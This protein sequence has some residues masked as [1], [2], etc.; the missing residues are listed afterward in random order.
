[1]AGI[2]DALGA[3]WESLSWEKKLGLMLFAGAMVVLSGGT[4]GLAFEVGMGVATVLGSARGAASLV[5]DPQGTVTRYLST[6]T[7]TEI[8]LDLATAALTT[9]GA[10]A[11]SAMGGQM[12]RG[13][14]AATREAR[15]ASWLWRTDRTAW[16]H[17]VR[18]TR[19]LARDETG[20]TRLPDWNPHASLRADEIE[21]LFRYR[22]QRRADYYEAR[23]QLESQLPKGHTMKH[24]NSGK[25]E[26]TIKELKRNG[27]DPQ[28][29]KSLDDA[30]TQRRDSWNDWTGSST[31]IGETGGEAYL[32]SQGYHI[33]DE[34]LSQNVPVNNGTVPGGWLDGMAVSPNGDEIV[35]SEYKGVTANL[36][37]TS[38]PTLY[39]GNAKQGTPAYTRDR[40]LSDPRVAQYF[41]DHPDVWEG[42]KSGETEL[43]IKVMKTKAEDLTQITDEP[44]TLTP[45]VIQHLQQNIDNL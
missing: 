13:A 4:L 16:R 14:Y 7:P 44:F 12:A 29:T 45:E 21:E 35:I 15:Y 24:Y 3:A 23:K 43:T 40:M 22:A 19:R 17:Y 42:V 39:E 32:E 25:Y 11:A 5:R 9:V 20:A 34:F 28:A 18:N 30:A 1:M 27:Y 6:H 31:R 36:D 26:E 38:H 2:L 8:A 10:G 41:H 37:G 33:P